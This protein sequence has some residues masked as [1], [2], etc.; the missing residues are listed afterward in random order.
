M[1]AVAEHHGHPR[2]AVGF[3]LAV[4]QAQLIEQ[5]EVEGIALGRPIKAD[6]VHV[7]TT[8]SADAAGAGLIHEE[9]LEQ[10]GRVRGALPQVG[11]PFKR[12]HPQ[13]RAFA[14]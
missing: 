10:D 4:S 14:K 1:L 12:H 2:F 11:E 3:E 13:G 7:T 9:F 5:I 8:F 6:Q